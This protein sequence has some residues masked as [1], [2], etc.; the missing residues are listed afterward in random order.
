MREVISG[1]LSAMYLTCVPCA[2]SFPEPWSF[3][4]TSM[5][6]MFLPT[7]TTYNQEQSI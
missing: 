5:V 1:W 2:T 3:S 4:T 7:L 6:A